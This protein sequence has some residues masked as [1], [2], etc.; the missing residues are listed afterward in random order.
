MP[1]NMFVEELLAAFPDAKVVITNRDVD[2]WVLSITSSIGV[3]LG[4]NWGLVSPYDPVIYALNPQLGLDS[5]T[6]KPQVFVRPYIEVA[7]LVCHQWTGGNWK[8]EE[9]L[10]QSFR[11]HY[12]LI[13]AKVPKDRLL[14]FNPK[15]GW[16]PLCKHLG[17]KVP[18]EPYPHVN[19]SPSFFAV[20]KALWWRTA[21]KAVRTIVLQ[22]LVPMSAV[23]AGGFWYWYQLEG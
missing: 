17:R 11:D 9:R 20:H 6:P 5:L 12:A 23:A 10:G 21:R 8:D 2:S 7:N 18:E 19:H 15:D 1:G 4:W 22:A 16:G 3:V 14:E 13:R